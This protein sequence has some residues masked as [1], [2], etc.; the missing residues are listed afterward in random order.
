MARTRH[1]RAA[2][3]LLNVPKVQRGSLVS[4]T[5]VDGKY[6]ILES[7]QSNLGVV[8]GDQGPWVYRILRASLLDPPGDGV[9][10]LRREC[11][12]ILEIVGTNERREIQKVTKRTL[13][14]VC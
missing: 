5:I 10:V 4:T 6:F 8:D 11:R 3:E 1:T 9:L 14:L 12:A 2:I 13:L 7:K